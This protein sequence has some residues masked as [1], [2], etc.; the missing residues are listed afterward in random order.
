ME[1]WKT[2]WLVVRS[3]CRGH[4]LCK[5][6]SNT[7]QIPYM[8]LSEFQL[9]L[10]RGESCHLWS[11]TLTVSQLTSSSSLERL[12]M[13]LSFLLTVQGA[14]TVQGHPL[15]ERKTVSS[16]GG[17][18]VYW[19]FLYTTGNGVSGWVEWLQLYPSF[20]CRVYSSLISAILWT[21]NSARQWLGCTGKAH[22]YN[23]QS[24]LL[25]NS[26]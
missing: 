17:M 14:A 15:L 4:Y 24:M 10:F 8:T 21:S 9:L 26:A 16:C 12:W 20:S 3:Y 18:L 22:M 6:S 23:M 1:R 13:W 5:N 11:P 7:N 2:S 19:C 25:S